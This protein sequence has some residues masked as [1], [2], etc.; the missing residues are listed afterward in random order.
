MLSAICDAAVERFIAFA[1]AEMG[2]APAQFA[3]IAM[4]SHGRQEQTLLTD[5]DNA[6]IFVAPDEQAQYAAAAD[7]FQRL[8]SKV[9]AWL[10]QAGYP[11]CKG[12]FMASNP[13]WCRSLAEWQKNFTGWITRAEP[14][15]L[16]EFSIFFDFRTV[17]GDATLAQKL[18]QHVHDLLREQP[19]F[20]PHLARNALLFSPPFRLFGNIYLGGGSAE[21]A[22]QLNLKDT[23]MS[24]VDFARLYAL[25]HAID[26]T[27]T[28]DRLDELVERKGLIPASR[29]EVVA[30]YDFV[31]RLRLQRQLEAL[32]AGQPMDNLVNPRQLRHTEETLLRQAFS[33]IAAVQKKINYDFFGTSAPETR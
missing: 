32:Q 3:F 29:D 9:C 13:R 8:G 24:I 22:G 6:I 26:H 25:R 15:E 18:R 1:Q 14:Q 23:V 7:Y 28:L 10:A 19:A 2:A 20:F 4:G 17:Y 31:M 12:N 5:Q 30:S 27:H 16:L 11:A 33:Q 21:H